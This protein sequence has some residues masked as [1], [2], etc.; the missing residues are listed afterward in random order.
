MLISGVILGAELLS[1]PVGVFL[2]E[3][4]GS[5]FTYFLSIP[6]NI[7]ALLIL[8]LIPETKPKSNTEPSTL[9][10]LTANESNG[11]SSEH[12]TLT[13]KVQRAFDNLYG[14]IQADV[15]PLL[16][17]GVIILGIF[18]LFVSN[19]VRPIFDLLIQYMVLRFSW[20]Y[21]QVSDVAIQLRICC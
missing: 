8:F 7:V 10:D 6:W 17:R 20:K 2:M 19:F 15:I 4:Y 13:R 3:R 21:S 12:P 9:E 14:H 5:I 18:S 11:Q 16:S 1:P